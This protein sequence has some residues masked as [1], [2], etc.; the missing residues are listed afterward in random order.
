MELICL[1]AA[2]IRPPLRVGV[3]YE[4]LGATLWAECQFG[5]METRVQ[6]GRVDGMVFFL[7]LDKDESKNGWIHGVTNPCGVGHE[8]V[9]ILGDADLLLMFSL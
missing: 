2:Q 7:E 5:H 1:Q 8:A 6:H 3:S 9:A 4:D